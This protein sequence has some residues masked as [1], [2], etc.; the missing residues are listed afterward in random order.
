LTQYVPEE[1]LTPDL[2]EEIE[3]RFGRNS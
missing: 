1:Y 3:E 2:I